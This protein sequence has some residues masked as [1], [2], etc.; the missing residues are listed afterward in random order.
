[1]KKPDNIGKVVARWAE[2]VAK[3][4]TKTDWAYQT[5]EH[6]YLCCQ[7]GIQHPLWQ[8]LHSDTGTFI[9]VKQLTVEMYISLLVCT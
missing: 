3:E 6:N 4:Q 1:M 7:H 8:M 2:N 9:C 5:Q